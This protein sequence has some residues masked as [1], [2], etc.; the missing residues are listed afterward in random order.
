[1]FPHL[2]NPLKIGS[3]ELSN[4][5]CFLAHRTNFGRKGRLGERHVNYYRRRAMGGSGLIVLGELSIMDNDYPWEGMIETYNPEA[6]SDFQ[7]LTRSVG[8]YGTRIFAQLTHHGFQSNGARTRMETWGSSAVADVVFGE[9]CKPMEPED[10]QELIE[11]F[12]CAAEIVRAGG[13]DGIEIDMGSESL[14]RQFLSL[15][16]NHRKDEYGGSL[17]NRMRLPLAVLKAVRRAVGDDYPVGVRLC[18]DEKFWGGITPE[19]SI[20]MAQAME[21]T[22]SIDF[23]H[24]TLGTYYNLYMN[25]ASMHTPEGHTIELAQQLKDNVTIPVMAA[26]HIRFPDMAESVLSEDKADAVGCVRAL[27][28]DPDLVVKLRS[29]DTDS[30]RPCLKDNQG[31]IGRINQGKALGCTFNSQVGYESSLADR[32]GGKPEIRKK[33]M[34]VGAGPAGMEAALTAAQK[35]HDVALY[36]SSPDIGGKVNTAAKGAGR[37]LLDLLVDYYRGMLAI[38]GVTVHLKTA[39]TAEVVKDVG[40]DVLI[41]A[42]GARPAEKP[43][44]GEYEPPWVLSVPDILN[45]THPVGD[46]V[47][48]ID[49]NGS[50]RSLA[51]AELLADQG[52]Q[53]DV[54]T[55]DLFVGVELAP[56][57][58]LYLTRQRLLQKGV[59]FTTDVK[60]DEIDAERVRA[61]RMYTG[62]PITCEGYGTIVVEAAYVPEDSLY[63]QAKTDGIT[64]H[65]IGDCVAPRT[66]EMAVYEGRK[67]GDVL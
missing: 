37:S 67:I 58:D 61:H 32:N 46:K 41:V 22:G 3:I 13:F 25:M 14:L 23:L 49:E 45:E 48:L 33:I 11:A 43:F 52:K 19:E 36:E 34:I 62:E 28:C 51:T 44:A 6:L 47:L 27:I 64:A 35:G 66:I 65:T 56:V 21:Q 16:S 40:P 2:L 12:A 39:V 20:P 17:E 18:V 59:T 57:G 15:V 4:R 7:R 30:I 42:T 50:H 53:V 55:N 9:V 1:M 38:A 60:V 26:D 63:H 5:V 29:G 31:C 24:A 10:I 8:E 54:L